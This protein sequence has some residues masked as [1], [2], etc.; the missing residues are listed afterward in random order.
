MT[1]RDYLD[2]IPTPAQRRALK[3][4]AAHAAS[5]T[6]RLVQESVAKRKW[7]PA[8]PVEPIR[9]VVLGSYLD[10]VIA[11][12]AERSRPYREA[13]ALLAEMRQQ[14]MTVSYTGGKVLVSGAPVK[15]FESRIVALRPMLVVVLKEENPKQAIDE[16]TKPT[17]PMRKTP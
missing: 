17:L 14:G 2:P 15:P 6:V 1:S 5:E 7:P 3:E 11:R 9:S 13:I 16:D 10:A 12:I 4:A 8:P